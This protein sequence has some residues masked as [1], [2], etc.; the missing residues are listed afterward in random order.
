MDEGTAQ[1]GTSVSSPHPWV[2][3]VAILALAI[4]LR[5][6]VTGLSPL[7]PRVASAIDLSGTEVGLLGALPPFCFAVSALTGPVLLRRTAAEHLVLIALA[8]TAFGQLLRPW[9]G[10][11]G[12]FLALSVLALLGMGLGNVVLPVLV[13]SW[14]PERIGRV[15]AVYV[16]AVTL[17][18]ALPPLFAV[19]LADAFGWA[20]GSAT[21]GWQW[22]LASWGLFAALVVLPW[23]GPVARPRATPESVPR[24]RP[25]SPAPPLRPIHHSRTAWGVLLVFGGTSLNSYSLFAWLPVRLVDAGLGEA[26]AGAA[27]AVFAGV[28]VP[29]SLVVPLVAARM[30]HQF[31]LVA[32]FGMCFA[33]GLAG[34][35]LLP[36]H[37]TLL[38]AFVTGV[39]GSGFPLSLTLVGL[40]TRDPSMAG[41]LSG[42]AQGFGY[43]GAGIGP[44]AVGG[45]YEATGEWTAPFVLLGLTLPLLVLGGWLAG[46]DRTVEDD[47]GPAARGE[48]RIPVVPPD[49]LGR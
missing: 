12:P 8:L 17:G 30:R 25:A 36:G 18:T 21:T 1:R 45:L 32:G 23:L 46:R 43:L 31:P 22:A 44:V 47:L 28:G 3:L 9:A 42:F 10:A 38:W 34:L 48:V 39:G 49:T 41:R 37:G 20:G 2:V 13:K 27:V 7:L 24:V 5:A 6:A 15:T 35:L 40:R 14:F 29:A 33:A 16:T 4:N 19:P 26:M 11:P